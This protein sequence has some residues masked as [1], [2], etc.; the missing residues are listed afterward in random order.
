[1]KI[2]EAADVQDSLSMMTADN[3]EQTLTE[4]SDDIEKSPK[5]QLDEKDEQE[6]LIPTITV[7]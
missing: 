2:R 4:R 3:T 1:M 5:L 7:E 6:I